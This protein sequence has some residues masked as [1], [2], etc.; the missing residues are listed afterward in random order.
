MRIEKGQWMSCLCGENSDVEED[1]LD[2]VKKR[3]KRKNC[4]MKNGNKGKAKKS[5]CVE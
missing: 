1:C 5:H 2:E 4:D 3:K